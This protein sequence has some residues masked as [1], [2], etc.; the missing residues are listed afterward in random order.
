MMITRAM[1]KKKAHVPRQHCF[2]AL[3]SVP[4]F[5]EVRTTWDL[6]PGHDLGSVPAESSTQQSTQQ[7]QRTDPGHTV[8]LLQPNQEQ[9]YITARSHIPPEIQEPLSKEAE[10]QQQF[11]A[12]AS[13]RRPQVLH[14]THSKQGSPVTVVRNR[15]TGSP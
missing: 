15:I 8:L 9:P 3:I 6:I 14:R 11:S 12:I 13:Q 1:Q 4:A 10:T 7:P 2:L 5:Q